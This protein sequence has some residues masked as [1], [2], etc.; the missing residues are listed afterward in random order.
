MQSTYWSNNL[1]KDDD[2]FNPNTNDTFSTMNQH[3]LQS[4]KMFNAY[5]NRMNNLQAQDGFYPLPWDQKSL[6]PVHN[7]QVSPLF[8]RT[9]TIDDSKHFI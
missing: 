7:N 2:I 3:Q 1:S 9:T 4:N 8:H 6:S 5:Q